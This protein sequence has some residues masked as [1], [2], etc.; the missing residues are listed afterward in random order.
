MKI[1][2]LQ[3]RQ[4]S[5]WRMSMGNR[6]R[7]SLGQKKTTCPGT[8]TASHFSN[9]DTHECWLFAPHTNVFRVKNIQMTPSMWFFLHHV[10]W[11][12]IDFFPM[13]ADGAC[14]PIMPHTRCT[15]SLSH[16]IS[17]SLLFILGR[18]VS[19]PPPP[20]FTLFSRSWDVNILLIV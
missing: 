9:K 1:A 20:E 13:A 19:P 7:F 6:T 4:I 5:Q 12:Q 18:L 2:H 15:F 14:G 16:F 11:C 8:D 3:G 17:S 10:T